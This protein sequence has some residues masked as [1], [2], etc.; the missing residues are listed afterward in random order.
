MPIEA[1]SGTLDIENAKLRVSEFSATTSIGIGTENTEQ[2]P[3]YI[4]K[5]VKPEI[6][7]QDSSTSA[8][9]FTS[10]NGSLTIQS[11][12]TLSDSSDGD[13]VFSDMGG[14]TKHMTIKGTTG[15]IGIGTTSPSAKL[16]VNGGSLNISSG[17][18]GGLYD[19]GY[20]WLECKNAS[21]WY[22]LAQTPKSSGI[23]CYNGIAINS[24]GG[25][26]VGSWDSPNTL[27]VGNAYFAGNVGIGILS[28]AYKLDVNGTLRASNAYFSNM[29]IGGSTSRG[30]RSVSGNYGTVQTTGG[31]AGNYEG[32]SIDGRYVFMSADNNGCGIYNDLD[33]EWMIWCARNSD[34]KLYFDGGEKLA[35]TSTGVSVTGDILATGDITAYSDKRLKSNITHIENA[36]DKVTQLNGYTYTLNQTNTR[37][38]GLI[39]QEVLAVLPEAVHGS[40]DTQYSLAYG[41]L[42]GLAVEAIKELETKLASALARLDALESA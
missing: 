37:S 38:T 27:G 4:Y 3:L 17:S 40:E 41:N 39:A 29:Y 16:H 22:R 19:N 7:I 2:Y 32:Y 42:M 28:P 21:D 14:I 12:I 20:Q 1:P 33:N 34:T 24:G 26:V 15:Y 11:G 25:L 9:K 30:L 10:N 23:A 18:S 36:L 35:T 6:I 31:G 13:I 8:A 5:D